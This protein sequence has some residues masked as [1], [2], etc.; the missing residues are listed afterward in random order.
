MTI[1]EEAALLADALLGDEAAV[2]RL[3]S[4]LEPVVLSV[5]RGLQAGIRDDVRNEIREHFWK[6]NF[7]A[8]QSWSQTTPIHRFAYRIAHNRM[9]DVLR[10]LSSTAMVH[11]A[12]RL[13]AEP[14]PGQDPE[15]VAVTRR[16]M[17]CIVRCI[18]L[19]EGTQRRV[20]EWRYLA[21]LRNVEIA[22]QLD[23]NVNAV[24]V[25]FHRANARLRQLVATRCRDHLPDDLLDWVAE[26]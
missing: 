3:L 10:G 24:N 17:A 18:E 21:E 22:R 19:L 1:D 4:L 8:L 16:L 5:T 6:Q 14:E 9:V 11:D 2:R 15:G 25:A 20:V 23:T 13:E 7:R 12:E 26:R